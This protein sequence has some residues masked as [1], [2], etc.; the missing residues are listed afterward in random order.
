MKRIVTSCLAAAA[1]T[2]AAAIPGTAATAA[3]VLTTTAA[4]VNAPAVV[5][6]LT[7][8]QKR[9]V[10]AALRADRSQQ[11]RRVPPTLV[12]VFPSAYVGK[13]FSAGYESKR[14]CI[15]RRESNGH[16]T[17]VSSGGTYRGAY[18]M[19]AALGRGAAWMMGRPDLLGDAVSTWS[20]FEQDEAFWTIFN[21][22]RGAQHWAGGRWSC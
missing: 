8:K 1:L 5:S 15:V 21:N 13:Y 10:A 20:R 4:A 12:G 11:A 7:D 22:G 6:T 3:P 18:Q 16:Y 17:A 19:S 9:R 2:A 14:R